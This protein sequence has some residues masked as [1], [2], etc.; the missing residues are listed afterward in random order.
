MADIGNNRQAEVTDN[1]RMDQCRLR[2][3]TQGQNNQRQGNQ[4]V[5]KRGWE[6]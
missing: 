3:D 4:I 2:Q 5:R 6:C 1:K